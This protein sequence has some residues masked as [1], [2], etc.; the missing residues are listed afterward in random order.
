MNYHKHQILLVFIS[1][2]STS[3]LFAANIPIFTILTEEWQPYNFKK[4]GIV[5]GI[6][7]DMLVLMLK[8]MGAAQKRQDIMLVP[9]ARGYNMLQNK[10]GTILFTTTMTEERKKMFKW[11]GPIFEIELNL[12]ALKKRH[13]KINSIEDI[14]KYRIGTQ[15]EDV[16]ESLLVKKTGMKVTQFERVAAS[17]LNMKKLHAGRIDIVP[18]CKETT[19]IK[20]REAGLDP[21]EF[22]PVYTLDKKS[23]YYAFHKDT[24]DDVISEFQS[25]FDT[26]KKEGKLAEIFRKYK[27]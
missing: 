13:I 6:S 12:Y 16:V 18:Q 27:N 17:I 10:P 21:N 23:N 8:K 5:Q 11:V 26:L 1:L 9:W 19:I 25:A 4:D 20:C 15:R 2:I 7:T 14:K 22:E 3:C 24:S